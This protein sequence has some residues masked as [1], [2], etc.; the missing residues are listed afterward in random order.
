M[1]AM[2]D[3]GRGADASVGGARPEAVELVIVSDDPA[4][5]FLLG[6]TFAGEGTSVECF[7]DTT[8]LAT[9]YRRG[10]ST[11]VVLVAMPGSAASAAANLTRA[12]APGARLVLVAADTIPLAPLG[13]HVVLRPVTF[14]RVYAAVSAELRDARRAG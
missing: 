14:D 13:A 3:G 10:G 12:S 9:W 6:E 1:P 7:A 5:T 2:R 11:R 8:A 4:M